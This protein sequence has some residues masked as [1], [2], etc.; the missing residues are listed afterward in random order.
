MLQLPH[1]ASCSNSP[2]NVAG[3]THVETIEVMNVDEVQYVLLQQPSD[4]SVQEGIP[5]VGDAGCLDYAESGSSISL[6]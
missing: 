5:E 3:S 1:G 4:V 2:R 6:G